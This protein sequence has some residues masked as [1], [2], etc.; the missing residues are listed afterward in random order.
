[1]TAQTDTATPENSAAVS[2]SDHRLVR[3]CFTCTSW[4]RRKNYAC[5]YNGPWGGGTDGVEGCL[6]KHNGKI[7]PANDKIQ[8]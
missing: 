2:G 6:W 8:P 7:S 1:M 4:H 5:K 3:C